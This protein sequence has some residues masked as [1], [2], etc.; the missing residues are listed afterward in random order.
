M[1]NWAQNA[2]HFEGNPSTIEAIYSS[3]RSGEGDIGGLVFDYDVLQPMPES[4]QG[5]D[6]ADWCYENRGTKW[7]STDVEVAE[8]TNTSLTLFFQ[9]AWS[10]PAAYSDFLR[11]MFPDLKI[12]SGYIADSTDGF[13]VYDGQFDDFASVFSIIEYAEEEQGEDEPYKYWEFITNAQLDELAGKIPS[14]GRVLEDE[15][16]YSWWQSSED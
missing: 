12:V 3:V 8:K 11:N 5:H 14:Y 4:L 10:G 9:S 2:V 1:A 13:I 15:E 16:A 6:W 7:V